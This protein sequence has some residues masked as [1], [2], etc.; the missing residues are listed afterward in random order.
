M[1]NR[2]PRTPRILLI[3]LLS[4]FVLQFSQY[5]FSWIKLKPLDGY[6]IDTTNIGF[7]WKDWFSTAYQEKEDNYLK[8]HF[9]F[10]SFFIRLNHQWRF[11]LFNKAKTQWVT[12]G[13]ENYLFEERYIDTWFGSDY[14]G[15]DSIE[16]R[17]NKLKI[18]QDTLNNMGKKI[19]TVLAP[20]K[21]S[22]FPEFIPDTHAREKG[23]TNIDIY[24]E[25]IEKYQINCI[26]FH[27]FFIDNKNS[28]LYPL[29]PQYDIHWSY[30]GMCL[31]LDSMVRYIE[32]LN[33]ISMPHV[34]WE[35]V[36]ISQPPK[37]YD[38]GIAKAMNLL[39]QPRTF[40][41]AYPELQF[42]PAE[43]KTK[44]SLLVVA[45]SFYWGIF[46]MGLE[47]LFTNDSFWYYNKEIYRNNDAAHTDEVNL[48]DEIMKYDIIMILCTDANLSH[49]G[50]EFIENCYNVFNN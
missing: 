2:K 23:V 19:I 40:N 6:Y 47:N 8:D 9:G 42:E 49:L 25:C 12:I 39:F 4:L 24:R 32:K 38:C 7:T 33:K 10:R 15:R 48:R 5:Q 31:A 36:K 13:K 37:D 46:G 20:G 41:M 11:S 16:Q 34:Y 22:F 44:P 27:Q 14:I 3:I 18:L 30:Y 17:I 1:E 50:W 35:T 43:G 21:G 28:S 29:Y 26:D 45:D